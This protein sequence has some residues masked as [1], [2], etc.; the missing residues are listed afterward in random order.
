MPRLIIVSDIHGFYTPWQTVLEILTSDDTLVVAGDLF[1]TRYG[2]INDK[3][4]QP[5]LIR[6]EFDH[7][8]NDKYYVY[9]NCDK[10]SF[11]PGYEFAETFE[12]Q[13]KNYM[14]THGHYDLPDEK[15]GD[16]RIQGH[17]HKAM[18]EKK[19]HTIWVNPGSISLP[20]DTFRGVAIIENREIKLVDM[21]KG[22]VHTTPF[23]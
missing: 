20:R 13:G 3:D 16:I 15:N 19:G 11:Y 14:L 23:G 6:S 17:T 5:E 8:K 18:I 21:G 22:A 9:G 10:P 2:H 12:F 4:F 7:L 1:D